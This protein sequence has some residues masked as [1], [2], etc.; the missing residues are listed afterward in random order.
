MS[1]LLCHVPSYNLFNFSA[2]GKVVQDDWKS[3]FMAFVN[4]T[5]EVI[6]GPAE[7]FETYCH[8]RL[9]YF[10]FD[11]QTCS[12]RVSPWMSMAANFRF[13]AAHHK[14][15]LGEV[16]NSTEWTLM[17]KKIE[18]I[19]VDDR[20]TELRVVFIYKRHSSYYIVTIVLPLLLLSFLA[21]LI[22]PLP[23]ESGEKISLG[24]SCLVSFT[25]LQVAIS[26]YLPTSWDTIPIISEYII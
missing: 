16:I 3:T 8:M 14:L 26:Q 12:L 19:T 10:P 21:L 23:P 22:F 4:H 2:N 5:G 17:D 15:E 7:H 18:I 24:M 11:T 20:P 6:W 25:V 13:S 9:T 1:M